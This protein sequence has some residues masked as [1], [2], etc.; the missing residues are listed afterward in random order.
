MSEIKKLSLLY[1]KEKIDIK[2]TELAEEIS[3]SYNSREPILIGVLNGSFI[4]LADLIRKLSISC[5]LD[6][7]KASS[8]SGFL[9]TGK[10]ELVKDISVDIKNRHVILVE[11]I[12]D[13]GATIKFLRKHLMNFV[14]RSFSIVTLLKRQKTANL[15]F[16]IDFIGFEVKEEFVVG[17][18]LDFDQNY[19][20]L[21]AIYTLN[22]YFKKNELER[23]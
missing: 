17:F 7:I 6:F 11:D 20:N 18:G 23:G 2:I 5:T 8:Y 14:P 22:Q 19:R 4:F 21:G 15:D 12:I 1:S 10:V 16:P 13:S 3:K 9:S